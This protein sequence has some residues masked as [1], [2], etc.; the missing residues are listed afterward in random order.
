MSSRTLATLD[1]ARDRAPAQWIPAC[2]LVLMV[3]VFSVMSPGFLTSFNIY[4]VGQ[5]FALLALIAAGVAMTML[6]A[7]I[8]L[9]VSAMASVAGVVTLRAGENNPWLGISVALL[10]GATVGLIN[11]LAIVLFDLSSL[12]VTV[13]TL[14]FLTG[15]TYLLAEGAAVMSSNFAP[16]AW[17]DQQ[18]A[19]VLSPRLIITLVVLF[20][21]GAALTWTRF[22]RDVIATGSARSLASAAGVPTGPTIVIA[23]IISSLAASLAGGL[24]ALSL[25]SVPPT[26][27]G[28]LLLQAVTI[29][30]VGGVALSG[31]V[32]S[33]SGVAL[34]A[35]IIVVLANGLASVG[36][37]T[38]SISLA[39]GLVLFVFLLI[40]R[41]PELKAQ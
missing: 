5:S 15:L 22:G 35:G 39:T 28:N 13:A 24:L 41:R 8:D 38:A 2:F 21:L 27:N 20:C 32:G 31:G 12:V 37:N 14:V 16:G 36:A 29:A 18:L 9:S 33:M 26:V 6:V 23:F 10:V 19:S 25:A 40:N 4:S 34:G 1:R 17:L 7:E 3:L 11:G 30:I